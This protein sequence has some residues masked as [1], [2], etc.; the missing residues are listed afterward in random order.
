[1]LLSPLVAVAETGAQCP[2]ASFILALDIG[3][4]RER[5]GAISAR[6]RSEWRFNHALADSVRVTLEQAG[7]QLVVINPDGNKI[8]LRARTAQAKQAQAHLFLSLHHDSVQPHYLSTWQY[9]GQKQ[10]YSDRYAGYSLFYSKRNPY[11]RASRVFARAFGG[12]LRV[13]G[14]TPSL[15]HAEPIP[16]ENRPLIDPE[17]GVYRFDDLIVLHSATMPAVLFEAGIIVN[18]DEE[19]WIA[20]PQTRQAIADALLTALDWYCAKIL[21]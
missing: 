3:H 6:G 9:E 21:E 7:Y 4:S 19:L 16:K 13:H 12:Q 15:H 1:M 20:K 2:R 17:R 18:R 10:R 14:F 5:P 8:A 11:A